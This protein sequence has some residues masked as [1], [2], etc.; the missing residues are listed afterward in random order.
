MEPNIFTGTG[1]MPVKKKTPESRCWFIIIVVD[2]DDGD[3]DFN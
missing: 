2:D 3:D 1:T